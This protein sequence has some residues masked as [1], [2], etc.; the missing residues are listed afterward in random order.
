MSICW[1]SSSRP[2]L[3][4]LLGQSM[5]LGTWKQE[6]ARWSSVLS[7]LLRCS[8]NSDLQKIPRGNDD[9]IAEWAADVPTSSGHDKGYH[10]TILL[11]PGKTKGI[12]G[13]LFPFCCKLDGD[14]LVNK[15]KDIYLSKKR[16]RRWVQA[17]LRLQDYVRVST[18]VMLVGKCVWTCEAAG[19]PFPRLDW[20]TSFDGITDPA[21]V[22]DPADAK[23][24]HVL[25]IRQSWRQLLS[26]HCTYVLRRSHHRWARVV[27]VDGTP[28]P[29]P[30]QGRVG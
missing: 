25:P 29:G 23:D 5:P 22:S 8:G 15:K 24:S 26:S 13:V 11:A 4:L 21:S 9:W 6:V 17:C 28:S 1:V 2:R 7:F 10:H 19:N 3:L 14:G 30:R 16:R 18:D 20:E 27:P 12:M